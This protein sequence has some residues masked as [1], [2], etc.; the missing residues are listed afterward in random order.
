M[1]NERKTAPDQHGLLASC[2]CVADACPCAARARG[3]LPVLRAACARLPA[4]LSRAVRMHVKC[5]PAACAFVCDDALCALRRTAW[6]T[7]AGG[8]STLRLR[9]GETPGSTTRP[10]RPTPPRCSWPSLSGSISSTLPA[11][12]TSSCSSWSTSPG[13]SA[14]CPKSGACLS[15]RLCAVCCV[16]F[17]WSMRARLCLWCAIW[18]AC[19]LVNV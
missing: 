16:L 3:L 2:C 7:Q 14:T 4:V 6:T 8:R 9:T 5:W 11:S 10:P 18:C 12:T 1:R 15:A 13:F 19:V 17:A